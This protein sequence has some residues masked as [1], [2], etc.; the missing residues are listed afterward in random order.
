MISSLYV[1]GEETESMGLA[2]KAV[3]A[4]ISKRK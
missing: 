4:D 2:G 3:I 1:E